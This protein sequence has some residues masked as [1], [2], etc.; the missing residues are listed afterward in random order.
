[1]LTD[2]TESSDYRIPSWIKNNARWWADGDIP[3]SAFVSGLQWL[4]RNGIMQIII[5]RVS[6]IPIEDVKISELVIGDKHNYIQIYSG[7]I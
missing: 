4:I 2:V 6:F 3:D 1:M 7:I 5:E